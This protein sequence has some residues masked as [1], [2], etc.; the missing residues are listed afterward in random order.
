MTKHALRTNF[1]INSD[2]KE[3]E[4]INNKLMQGTD[5]YTMSKH[6]IYGVGKVILFED[7]LVRIYYLLIFG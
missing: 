4:I 1:Q 5:Q 3:I 6:K 2:N 7:L